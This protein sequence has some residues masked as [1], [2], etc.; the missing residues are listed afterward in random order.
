MKPDYH[1]RPLTGQ[2]EPILWEALYLALHTTAGDT[3][4]SRDVVRQPEFGR[5]VEDWGRAGDR[6]FV[7]L[8]PESGELLG[9]VWFREPTSTGSPELAFAVAPGQRKRGIG[10]ALLT[11]W[12]RANPEQSEVVL[13]VNA[14]HPAVRLYE[15]F[16]FRIVQQDASS[17]TLRREVSP[18]TAS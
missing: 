7:A 4:A 9:S 3:P 10:A 8:D 18:G 2:D 15:R 11:Q 5:Y 12:V 17:V 1:M 16:G 14:S 6:G 13:R